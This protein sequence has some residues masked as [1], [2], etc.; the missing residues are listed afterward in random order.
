MTL[1]RGERQGET[2]EETGGM[3]EGV[4]GLEVKSLSHFGLS[5]KIRS[6]TV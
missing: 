1:R 4:G 3:G 2:V 6:H 5:L